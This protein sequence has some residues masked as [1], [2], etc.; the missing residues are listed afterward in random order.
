M[1]KKCGATIVRLI[2]VASGFLFPAIIGSNKV[3]AQDECAAKGFPVM[4]LKKVLN[5]T[6]PG[7]DAI[8]GYLEHLP[9]AYLANTNQRFPVLI[10]FHG[11][12]E[13]GFG[14]SEGLCN[15]LGQ[16]FL[17][18]PSLV[19]L[20]KFPHY[21]RDKQGNATQM[22][23]IA[24]QV[25]FLAGVDAVST[26]NSLI[27]Y[28]LN[29]YRIDP[30]RVY[31]S[32]ISEGANF[33]MNFA[34]SSITAAKRVAAIIPVSPCTVLSGQ[35]ANNIARANLP[36]W[37]TQCGTESTCS[38]NPAQV[39][40]NLINNQN[41]APNPRAWST[42]FP[43]GPWGCE[44]DP[45][46]TWNAAYD[47]TFK[48]VVNG[49]NVN[50]YDWMMQYQRIE[51]LPVALKD[52]TATLSNSKVSLRWTTTA[53]INNQQ[54]DIERAG[55]D[56][57]FTPLATIPAIG[58][59]AGKAYLWVD[60]H[61]LTNLNFYRL[62]QTDKDGNKKYFDIKK[63]LNRLKWDRTVIVSPNPVINEVTAYINL[64]KAQRVQVSITDMSGRRLKSTHQQYAEGAAE[65]SFNTTDLPKGMYFLKIEGEDF[66]EV[67]K[68]VKQ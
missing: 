46:N 60:E 16:W 40:A 10:F 44:A 17:I 27:T 7:S 68:L 3:A 64:H 9:P 8:K 13:S 25:N 20:N 21:V 2:L 56:Q 11:R 24:P 14:T 19:E 6:M 49:N 42:N 4:K 15:L 22:L 48:Q 31:L 53:E 52:F 35:Q 50:I 26:I 58:N 65:I 59:E 12:W 67:Q 37:A 47:T 39:N 61:P 38:G 54:F 18:P 23:L 36:F 33:I 57:R 45:H 30:S 63:V 51:L 62:S 32:G 41:P 55:A 1:V 5:V 66:S 43:T 29:K 28:L 34:S